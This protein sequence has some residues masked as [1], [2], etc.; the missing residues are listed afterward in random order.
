[1]DVL[2]WAPRSSAKT[3]HL[4]LAPL[5]RNQA[6][7][8]RGAFYL[9]KAW[10]GHNSGCDNHQGPSYAHPSR[11]IGCGR[12]CNQSA[13]NASTGGAGS[14]LK[15]RVSRPTAVSGVLCIARALQP[16]EPAPV[17]TFEERKARRL[18]DITTQMDSLH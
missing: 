18:M 17:L 1:M 10:G 6:D 5:Q 3:G 8:F 14:F 4:R 12:A 13:Y 16:F 7:S 2:I 9:R 15:A 11:A